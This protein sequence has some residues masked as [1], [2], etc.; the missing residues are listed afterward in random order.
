MSRFVTFFVCA[1]VATGSVLAGDIAGPD[2]ITPG[3]FASFTSELDGDWALFPDMPG[4][5]AKDTG[6]KALYLAIPDCGVY[7]VAHFAIVD[8]RPVIEQ[9]TLTVGKAE[10]PK[11]D[12]MEITL[13][14][15]EQ[16]ALTYAANEVVKGLN[17]GTITTP[18]AA[19]ATF[20]LALTTK[21]AGNISDAMEA[22]LKELTA[23]GVGTLDEIKKVMIEIT[24]CPTG[25]C[26]LKR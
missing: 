10:P 15:A 5:Y 6:G 1:L 4:C 23:E 13:T 26:P 8:G 22:K 14:D 25:T 16:S 2:N 17:N 24:G 11:P 9:K 21:L 3:Q 20:R 18:Q 7:S 12:K 19:R